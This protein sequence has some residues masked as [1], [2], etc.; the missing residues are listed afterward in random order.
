MPLPDDCIRTPR[1]SRVRILQYGPGERHVRH[2]HPWSTLTLMVT[3]RV[4][5][6]VGQAEARGTALSVV[7]KPAGTEHEDRFGSEGALTLQV[8][9]A[10]EDE[11]LALGRGTRA[12]SWG[13]VHAGAIARPLLDVFR[14]VRAGAEHDSE[15]LDALIQESLAALPDPLGEGVAPDRLEAARRLLEAE[16]LPVAVL[17]RGV[18]VH[19]VHLARLFRRHFGTTPAGLRRRERARRAARL[20]LGGDR[21][22]CESALEAGYADQ[23]HMTREL[24]RATGMTPA[25]LRALVRGCVRSRPTSG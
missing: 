23:A 11:R 16:S 9:L 15:P 13:W 25:E 24:K 12:R 8:I 19:P 22:L 4:A 5:E 18:G 3:G 2:A 21:S 17:A 7:Y 10:P 1:G 6:R 20:V 14:A